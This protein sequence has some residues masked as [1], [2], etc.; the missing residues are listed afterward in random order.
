MTLRGRITRLPFS[1]GNANLP[2]L[3]VY[4]YAD[5]LDMI[6]SWPTLRAFFDF[7]DRSTMI[8]SGGQVVSIAAKSGAFT[9]TAGAGERGVY[10]ATAM[11][12]QP[13]LTLDG[14]RKYAVPG[15]M[16]LA[17]QQVT[18][19]SCM[20]STAPT[21]ASQMVLADA[22]TP[23]QAV[24]AGGENVSMFSN[25]L[26]LPRTSGAF[27]ACGSQ[28]GLSARG[29][30]RQSS[31]TAKPLSVWRS[32]AKICGSVKRLFLIRISSAQPIA[33]EEDN[34]VP[35][36]LVINPGFSVRLR[37]EGLKTCHLLICQPEKIA[38]VTVPFAKPWSTQRNANQCVLTLALDMVQ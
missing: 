34:P 12:G 6:L 23:S 17:D 31:G 29:C 27:T 4:D 8:E 13:G 14:T 1:T 37:K 38:H 5:L 2:R 25:A 30:S 16:A 18:W 11:N 33:V 28:L 24:Y 15:L 3:V 26:S 22:G 21:G 9:A 35:H 7:S 36:A 10:N 20:M 19:A 32:T